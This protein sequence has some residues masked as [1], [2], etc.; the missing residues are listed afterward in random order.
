[1]ELGFR[2]KIYIA[3]SFILVVSL[4]SSNI[5]SYQSSKKIIKKEINIILKSLATSNATAINNF[6][7]FKH[8]V[9]INLAKDLKNPEFQSDSKLIVKFRDIQKIMKSTDTFMG[10]EEDGRFVSSFME[11]K[12][13]PKEYITKNQEWYIKAKNL[14]EDAVSDVYI[15]ET[16]KKKSFSILSKLKNEDSEISGIIGASY[17]FVNMEKKIKNIKIDGGYAFIINSKGITLTHPNKS[18]IG[19]NVFALSDSLNQVK[20]SI[21]NQ[22][23][24]VL[25]YEYN[26]ESKLL[27]FDTVAKTDWKIMIATSEEAAY[28]DLN[29]QLIQSIL[30]T[31]GFTIFGTLF[32]ILILKKLFV[33]LMRL[34]EMINTLATKDADLT[35][36]IEVVGNDIIAQIGSGINMFIEKLQNLLVNTKNSSNENAAISEQLSVTSMEVGKRV[37]EESSIIAVT[38]QNGKDLLHEL[39]DSLEDAKKAGE[40]LKTSN[41]VLLEVKDDIEALHVKLNNTAMKDV[42]LAEKLNRTSQNTGEVQEVLMVIADIAD[43]TNLLALNAAIEA[44]RAGDHG[45][46]FAVVADEVRKLAEK[47][48]KSLI[49]INSTINVVVQSVQEVSGDMNNSSKDILEISKNG[50]ELNKKVESTVNRMQET[51]KITQ[52]TINDYITTATSLSD[53]VKELGSVDSLSS[54]NTRS[55]EEL[56]SA[57]EHLNKLTDELNRELTKYNT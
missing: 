33:P 2:N 45:R 12:E 50:E 22:K 25:V 23:S 51:T 8:D 16:T 38:S 17:D 47:T 57:S 27:A 36:R 20:E 13:M 5:F 53:I 46:G 34:N 42:E 31:L 35:S 21:L 48:Q 6:L 56:A 39:N 37:E 10:F 32:I 52:S 26:D 19:K 41:N 54:A 40:N 24:G 30:I 44:A 3:V 11:Y 1:V 49:E 9:F 15:S 43:Q 28:K 18:V 55:I 29:D 7:S 4:L 14:N